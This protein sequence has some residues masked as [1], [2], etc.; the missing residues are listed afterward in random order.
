M[1]LLSFTSLNSRLPG[2]HVAALAVEADGHVWAGSNYD[3]YPRVIRT[4]PLWAVSRFEG[5]SDWSRYTVYNGVQ[6]ITPA[7]DRGIW[8]GTGNGAS[9]L[10][11]GVWSGYNSENSGLDEDTSMPLRAPSL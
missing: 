11:D 5:G 1:I 3:P 7:K 8:V 4:V 9:R 2:D 6:A 10:T